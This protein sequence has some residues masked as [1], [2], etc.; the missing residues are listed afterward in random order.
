MNAKQ[1]PPPK[2]LT[3]AD[4]PTTRRALASG[5]LSQTTRH[6]RCDLPLRRACTSSTFQTAERSQC[7]RGRMTINMQNA[8]C[9][10]IAS[11]SMRCPFV[12]FRRLTRHPLCR[13][14]P[15]RRGHCP[16]RSGQARTPPWS[17]T[18]RFCHARTPVHQVFTLNVGDLCQWAYTRADG[19]ANHKATFRDLTHPTYKGP[20]SRASRQGCNYVLFSQVAPEVACPVASPW[21]EIR[22]SSSTS[23][24]HP[25]KRATCKQIGGHAKSARER[26][27]PA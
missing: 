21:S 2:A 12:P 11:H 20:P 24:S 9:H 27:T 5:P 7:V 14:A 6:S 17:G 16:W 18:T 23:C 1:R 13:L 25:R 3:R 22:L 15:L 19:A 10:P 4:S 26:A 8:K